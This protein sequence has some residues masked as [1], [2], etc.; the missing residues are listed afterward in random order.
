MIIVAA[1][2]SSLLHDQPTDLKA[3][4]FTWRLLIGLGCVPACIA[5]YFR[6]T[7]P[8]S[9]RFTMGIERNVQQAADDVEN[10]FKY[11]TFY[12]DPDVVP[13]RV[14][15]PRATKRDFFAHFSKWE[16]LKVLIG[17]SWSWFALDIAFFGLGLNNAII[18]Q[19]IGVGSPDNVYESLKDVCVANIIA[20]IAGL[21]PGFYA[22]M[23]LID[24]WGRKPI[25][26]MGFSILT[27]L[28]L[29]LGLAYKA[30]QATSG[31]QKAFL[32]LYCVA[33]FFQN[34]GP[35]TTTFIVPG[36]AFPTRYRSTASGK[37][38][39]IIA[40]VSFAYMRNIGG[41][42]AFVGHILEIFA[43][44][45]LT[46]VVSTFLIPETKNRTLEDLSNE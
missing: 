7:I 36:G 46:G 34:F 37:L 33:N 41:R 20:A 40:Q 27:V 23:F 22:T 29:I 4:D 28:F 13:Q 30:M 19:A 42:N 26:F 44:F 1:F 17:T 35:N 31:G 9:P 15:A 8:E 18:F 32:F 5:L 12:V 25:Q 3:C 38:G 24:S 10:Y 39:A 6:L 16:N 2:K 45:M 14:D 43:L 11:G 21:I